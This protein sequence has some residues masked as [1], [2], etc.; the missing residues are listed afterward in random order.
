MRKPGKINKTVVCH[1]PR[2][3]SDKLGLTR[4]PERMTDYREPRERE[5]LY[6]E[7]Y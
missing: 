7:I 4:K 6:Y 1:R 3:E 2:E 5:A